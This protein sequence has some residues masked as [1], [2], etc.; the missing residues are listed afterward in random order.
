VDVNEK[1]DSLDIQRLAAHILD[2]DENEDDFDELVE[3]N[4]K[5]QFGLDLDQF[6][7]LIT[8]LVPLIT[9][10]ESPITKTLYKGFAHDIYWLL[11]TKA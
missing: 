11:K 3:S 1:F 7:D 2:I 6:E 4:I 8:A 9:V 10:G 5:F